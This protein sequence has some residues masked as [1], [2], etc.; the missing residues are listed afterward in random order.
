MFVLILIVL[1]IKNVLCLYLL[2][3]VKLIKL[4]IKSNGWWMGY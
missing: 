2:D 4:C 3:N 1:L